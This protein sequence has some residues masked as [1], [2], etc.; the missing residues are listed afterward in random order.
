MATFL[1]L[2]DDIV[3]IMDNIDAN[4]GDSNSTADSS[5]TSGYD[6]DGSTGSEIFE[7]GFDLAIK[8]AGQDIYTIENNDNDLFFIGPITKIK[9]RLE[10]YLKDLVKQ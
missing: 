5:C 10:A 4:G 3:N 8:A 2:P 7:N 1:D 9:D 6:N